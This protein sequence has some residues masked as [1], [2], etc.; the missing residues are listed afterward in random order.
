V[1]VG[2]AIVDCVSGASAKVA[3]IVTMSGKL[4]IAQAGQAVALV[5]DRDIDVSRGA[6]LSH[7]GRQPVVARTL[8]VK[9]VWLSDTAFDPAVPYLLRTA[10]D[11]VPTSVTIKSLLDLETLAAKPAQTCV[12]ND[13]A[14]AAVKLARPAAVD[15]FADEP[16]TGNFLLIDPVTGA[17]VAGGTIT[18]AMPAIKTSVAA[19]AFATAS[20]AAAGSPKRPEAFRLTRAMLL[21]GICADL[22][23]QTESEAFARRTNAVI[24]LLRSAGVTVDSWEI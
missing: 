7:P 17:T 8:E 18:A 22:A 3:D 9:L 19:P 10:T 15:R 16:G 13:I 11:L 23:D 2:D 4:R 21:A 5:L 24:E 1:A 20:S 6:V 12:S 14:V